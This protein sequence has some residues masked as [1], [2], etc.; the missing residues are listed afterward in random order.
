MA[1][2]LAFLLVAPAAYAGGPRKGTPPGHAMKH[3]PPGLAKKGGLPPGIA[4]QFGVRPPAV[5]YVAIDPRYHDRA[6]FLIDGRW[7]LRTGF[8][9][10]LRIEIRD[11]L[12]L[13]AVPPPIPAARPASRDFVQVTRRSK[14]HTGLP[15]RDSSK[16][17]RRGHRRLMTTDDGGM[18][19]SSSPHP[20][21]PGLG[22]V[23]RGAL[24]A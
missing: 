10:S 14:R 9:S 16:V 24:P 20:T 7:T 15:T 2:V 19:E 12:R 1:V 17:E 22:L 21:S 6:W 3:N 18:R 4:K 8:D 5:V 23:A 11:A 13:P